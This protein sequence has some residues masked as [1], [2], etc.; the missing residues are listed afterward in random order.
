M[1]TFPDLWASYCKKKPK[2]RDLDAKV[3]M[4]SSTFKDALEL[5]Y[6]EGRKDG[7]HEG[8]EEAKKPD[9]PNPFPD[10]LTRLFNGGG[11]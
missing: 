9:E 1:K 2:L 8:F 6:E 11:K 10:L 4:T 7:R 3:Q 5:A